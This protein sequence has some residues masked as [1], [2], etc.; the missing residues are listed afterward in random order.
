MT[1]PARAIPFD[2]LYNGL[3]MARD[4]GYIRESLGEDGLAL[5]CYTEACTYEKKWDPITLLARGLIL[6]I[7]E[8]KVVATPFPKFF[9]F[10]EVSDHLPNEPFEVFEKMDGSLII[11]FFHNG[12]WRCATKGSFK[13]DQAQWAQQVLAY[14]DICSLEPGTTY[15]AEAIYPENRIVVHY[16]MAGLVLLGAYTAWG[17]ELDY[18]ELQYFSEALNWN[19]VE[20][21]SHSSLDELLKIAKALPPTREGFVIRFNSGLRIKIKGDEYCRIHRLIS[22]LSPLAMWEAM[23]AGDNL[24]LV[25]KELPEEFWVDFDNIVKILQHQIDNLI[26]NVTKL[27]E[28]LV[29]LTDKDVGLLLPK[30][31]PQWSRFVFPY[32][33]NK[34][35]LLSGR[36]REAVFRAI[37]PD[38]NK[39]EGYTPSSVMNRIEN[40]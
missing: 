32:R 8:K 12:K 10:G 33:K 23:K 36:N 38:S 37:R 30:L 35:D 31:P 1:H 13:S 29:T 4:L 15:L 2:Q 18:K 17:T 34:G 5:Y 21:H 11:I 24:E 14:S 3:I 6:D 40:E 27:A 28:G 26:V 7:V 39:L 20:R 19:I 25:R 9:N 16:S 22:R